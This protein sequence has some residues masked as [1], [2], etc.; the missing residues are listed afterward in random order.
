MKIN[1][2]DPAPFS[3]ILVSPTRYNSYQAD[4]K[5]LEY[6]QDHPPPCEEGI[7]YGALATV[8]IFS[9]SLGVLAT[10]LIQGR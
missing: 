8:G 10:I 7:E 4:L 3:G 5:V 6:I 2:L 1:T 9:F